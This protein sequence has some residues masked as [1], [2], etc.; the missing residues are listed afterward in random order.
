M[1]GTKINEILRNRIIKT[2]AQSVADIKTVEEAEEFLEGLLTEKELTGISK[3]LAVAYWLKKK[4]S[5]KNIADNLKVSTATISS[6]S[7]K[8]ETPG[9]KKALKNIE[10]EEWANVWSSKIKKFVG[11]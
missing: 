1:S 6:V 5:Y 10:A 4:R 9:I 8:M 7:A 3:R 2:L 11:K